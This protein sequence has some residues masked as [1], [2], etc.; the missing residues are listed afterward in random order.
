M[1]FGAMYSLI[2]WRKR[3]ARLSASNSFEGIELE[4]QSRTLQPAWMYA[5]ANHSQDGI[6]G[7]EPGGVRLHP[8]LPSRKPDVSK[9]EL[10]KK[11]SRNCTEN[12]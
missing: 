10:G 5:G 11:G 3:T 8:R 1:R 12:R 6:L 2:A 7:S 9:R 4:G